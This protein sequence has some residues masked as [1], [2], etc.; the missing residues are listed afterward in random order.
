MFFKVFSFQ[1]FA[2]IS[3]EKLCELS[4]Q[5]DTFLT[6]DFIIQSNAISSR[7][8]KLNSKPQSLFWEGLD[9]QLSCLLN[10]QCN[11]KLPELGPYQG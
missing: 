11:F 9:G 7:G 4:D 3:Q 10:E 1:I 2:L 6:S 8:T 5:D